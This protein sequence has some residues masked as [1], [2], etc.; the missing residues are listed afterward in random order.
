MWFA[1]AGKWFALGNEA[2]TVPVR[3]YIC[4]EDCSCRSNLYYIQRQAGLLNC[5]TGRL[6][7]QQPVICL[8]LMWPEIEKK[9]L[10]VTVPINS[11]T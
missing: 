7:Q 10:Q 1:K 3:P 6:C 9:Q 2:V 5:Q 11:S 4:L 8:R